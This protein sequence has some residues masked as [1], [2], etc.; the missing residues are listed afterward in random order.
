MRLDFVN[1][2]A[3]LYYFT[4]ATEQ[5]F[6]L[7]E[8]EGSDEVAYMDDGAGWVTSRRWRSLGSLRLVGFDQS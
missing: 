3:I 6:Q 7:V 2:E 4:M 5:F 1:P 8:C